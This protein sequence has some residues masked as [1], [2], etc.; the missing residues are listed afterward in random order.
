MAQAQAVLSLVH[1][2]GR[3]L[4]LRFSWRLGGRWRLARAGG[5]AAAAID[6]LIDSIDSFD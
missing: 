4:G 1:V 6:G 3:R 5:L 2:G